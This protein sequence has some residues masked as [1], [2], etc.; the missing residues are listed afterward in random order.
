MIGLRGSSGAFV[1]GSY[2]FLDKISSGI[3]IFFCSNGTFFE[4][5]FYI[6]WIIVL[7]PGIS[8]ILG[9]ILV[10]TAKLNASKVGDE[11]A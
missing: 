1:F 11:D 3:V 8:A 7:V 10:I 9:W 6:R 4:D 5:P 2:S